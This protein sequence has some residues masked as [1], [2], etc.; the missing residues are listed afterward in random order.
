MPESKSNSYKTHKFSNLAK[1]LFFLGGGGQE[2]E[3][4]TANAYIA[5]VEKIDSRVKKKAV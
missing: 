1:L 3:V 2:R 4:N 5:L